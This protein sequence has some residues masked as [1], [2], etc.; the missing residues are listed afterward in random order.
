MG[1]ARAIAC[2]TAAIRSKAL[3][4]LFNALRNYYQE[5]PMAS[6]QTSDLVQVADAFIKAFD[7][8]DWQRFKAP[9]SPDVAYEETGTGRR[10]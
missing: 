10:T 7:A 3:A 1:G 9:L 6:T 8:G 4:Y 2:P 5:V